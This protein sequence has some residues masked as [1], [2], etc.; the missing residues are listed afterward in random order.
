MRALT[1]PAGKIARS[2]EARADLLARGAEQV[3]LH[4]LASLVEQLQRVTRGAEEIVARRE[5]ADLTTPLEPGS[6]SVAE[7]FDH[8]ARTTRTF[9]PAISQALT[10]APELG[11]NR[12][13]RTGAL[14]WL[15]IRNLEP[16]YGIRFKVL[17]QLRP[18]RQDFNAAWGGF[19]ESQSEL[20]EILGAAAGLAIDEVRIESPVY[21]RISYNVYGA[22]CMLAAHERRHLWQIKGI[23]RA[24]DRRQT[25]RAAI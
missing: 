23:L 15:F 24:L 17:P 2:T 3:S 14:A 22:F 7:C 21:T 11:T 5:E 8:L 9:L 18:R 19:L 10:A 4:Q 13:L 6:W 12:R 20:L 25:L 1:Q 16:P